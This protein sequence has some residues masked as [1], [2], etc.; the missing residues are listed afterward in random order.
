MALT[1]TFSGF[2]GVD[3]TDEDGG[4][5]LTGES[6]DLEGAAKAMVNSSCAQCFQGIK[7]IKS[8]GHRRGRGVLTRE[9]AAARFF[10]GGMFARPWKLPCA[11]QINN[12]ITRQIER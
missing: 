1:M 3:E 6:L 4:S 11:R 5:S 8:K 12:V 10:V 2:V 9:M 7:E